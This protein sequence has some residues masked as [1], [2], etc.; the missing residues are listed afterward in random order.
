MGHTYIQGGTKCHSLKVPW[1]GPVGT[2]WTKIFCFFI[3]KGEKFSLNVVQ[4]WKVK[5]Q[6][7]G[8]VGIFVYRQ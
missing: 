4:K 1:W 7:E 8:F 6:L 2:I 5:Q 3:E